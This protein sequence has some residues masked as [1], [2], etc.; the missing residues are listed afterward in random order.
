MSRS[1]GHFTF[2]DGRRVPKVGYR[3]EELARAAEPSASERAGHQLEVYRCTY[4]SRWH[5]GSPSGYRANARY[6]RRRDEFDMEDPAMRIELGV[7]VMN[8]LKHENVAGGQRR[9]WVVGRRAA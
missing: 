1:V 4:C 3:T 2:R 5:L 7:R 6:Q 9:R 8:H